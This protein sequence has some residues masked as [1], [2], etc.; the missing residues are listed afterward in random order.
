MKLI[1]S[2]S[3]GSRVYWIGACKCFLFGGGLLWIALI[4]QSAYRNDFGGVLFGAAW[5]LIFLGLRLSLYVRVSNRA[6]VVRNLWRKHVLSLGPESV[7]PR[8]VFEEELLYFQVT[9]NE[10]R[11]RVWG[12]DRLRLAASRWNACGKKRDT[13]RLIIHLEEVGVSVSIDD[14]TRRF[15]DMPPDG[16]VSRVS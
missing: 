16:Q 13:E 8:A 4:V 1:A 5:T 7:R 2:D 15:L 10:K 14:K 12:Y 9:G 3:S 11:I 6:I